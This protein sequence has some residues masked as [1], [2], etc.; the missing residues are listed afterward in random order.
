MTER[1]TALSGFHRHWRN[2]NLALSPGFTTAFR[3]LATMK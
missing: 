1:L 2:F 3:V